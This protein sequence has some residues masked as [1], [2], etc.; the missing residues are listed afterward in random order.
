MGNK[1]QE[2]I[3]ILKFVGFSISA[4]VIQIVSFEL[5]QLLSSKVFGIPAD[6]NYWVCYLISLTLSVVWNFTFNRKFTFKSATNVP[7]AMLKVLGYYVVFTPLSICWGDALE[8]SGWN[9]TLILLVTMAVNFVTEFVFDEYVVF[10]DK[11]KD[12]AAGNNGTDKETD[13]NAEDNINDGE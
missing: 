5:L 1:K 6:K 7:I 12:S 4:G 10:R 3:K 9:D 13:S 11:K 2:I 8:A